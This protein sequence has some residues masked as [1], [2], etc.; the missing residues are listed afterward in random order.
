M[1]ALTPSFVPA[2]RETGRTV[3]SVASPEP[4]RGWYSRG[5]LPHWDH[6]GMIQS[7]NFRLSD[8]LP[9]SVLAR[10]QNELAL[11]S[12]SENQRAIELRRRIE[13]YL[14]AGHGECWLRRPD[15]ARLVES[16]L[17]HF[18]RERACSLGA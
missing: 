16:A 10:W 5:Y 8:S 1:P 2:S 18:D 6:P 11:P 7:I 12:Q 14:D 3:T 13:E 17:L 9:G 15:V 4:H